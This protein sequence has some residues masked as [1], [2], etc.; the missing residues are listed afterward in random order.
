MLSDKDIAT[1]VKHLAPRIDHWFCAGLP[2]A[3]ALPVEQLAVRVKAGIAGHQMSGEAEVAVSAFPSVAEALAAAHKLSKP[4]DR[5]VV[6]G[7]FLTVAGALQA[8]GRSA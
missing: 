3:R 6:F 1:V 4:D 5:I 2:G 8:S 7:S